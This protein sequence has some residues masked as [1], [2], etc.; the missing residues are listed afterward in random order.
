MRDSR[1]LAEAEARMD[2]LL[3]AADGDE[4][5]E[6][7]KLGLLLVVIHGDTM[8]SAARHTFDDVLRGIGPDYLLTFR[9][10]RQ[11]ARAIKA[12]R[13]NWRSRA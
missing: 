13:P 9:A 12:K 3:A 1:P 2:Y 7:A 5:R 4:L 6:L 10:L 8:S 11:V